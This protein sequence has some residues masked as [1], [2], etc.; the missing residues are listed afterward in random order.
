MAIKGDNIVTG[1]RG[2]ISLTLHSLSRGQTIKNLLPPR[3]KLAAGHRI[4]PSHVTRLEM[5]EHL[6]VSVQKQSINVWSI[7]TGTLLGT[8]T[9]TDDANISGI[10]IF[11]TSETP[12]TY[13]IV[14]SCAFG[15]ITLW[16]FE[17]DPSK[18]IVASKSFEH[19][20]TP[21]PD[22]TRTTPTPEI[23]SSTFTVHGPI[24][25]IGAFE[26]TPGINTLDIRETAHPNTHDI[27]CGFK[28]GNLRS[29]RV[30]LNKGALFVSSTGALCSL[31]DWITSV[32]ADPLAA[33]VIA[34][35]WDGRIRVW[36][37]RKRAL[38][39]SLVSD[40]RSAVLCLEVV[41]DLLIAGS[42]NGSLVVYD[43]SKGKHR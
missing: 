35:A 19:T 12:H 9:H 40:V 24:Q 5:N 26:T 16:K 11:P 37:E 21:I 27:L 25:P 3:S 41:G 22:Q 4:N 33:V 15:S 42:Y 14:E 1:G 34:G 28:D 20:I 29:W 30:V 32:H 2:Q 13:C 23:S 10:A 38:R 43:F 31:G 6:I 17:F 36:D 39:R 8:I 7:R 18:P